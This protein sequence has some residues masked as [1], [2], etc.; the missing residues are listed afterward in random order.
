[1]KK[2]FVLYSDFKATLDKLPDNEAGKLFK[3]ILDFVNGI[4]VKPDS[5]LLDVVFEPIKQQMVRDQE[6]YAE[7]LEKRRIAGQL[8][9]LTKANNAKQSLANLASATS[10]KESLA[11]LGD[12][13]NENVNENVSVT[14]ND[15]VNENEISIYI[16]SDSPQVASK[17]KPKGKHLFKNSPYFD[18][19]TFSEAFKTTQ[20]F[21]R[22]PNLDIELIHD[23]MVNSEAKGYMYLNWIQAAANWVSREPHKYTKSIKSS[24]QKDA[25][26]ALMTKGDISRAEHDAKMA[27]QR[28][29]I[30]NG[31]DPYSY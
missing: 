2:S 29:L 3:L 8:G 1:M 28:K 16:P 18:L 15:N 5:L 22:H 23:M 9:G 7:E 26:F 14:V 30:N 24:I 21:A 20:C 13:V 19:S 11:N 27:L 6:K 12:N 25:A 17:T 10:A 4:D 31:N